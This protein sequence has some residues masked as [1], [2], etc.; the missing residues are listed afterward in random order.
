[1]AMWGWPSRSTLRT[2]F[3][4]LAI[5]LIVCP[6]ADGQQNKKRAKRRRRRAKGKDVYWYVWLYAKIMG[7]VLA[8]PVLLARVA[9]WRRRRTTRTPGPRFRSACPGGEGGGGVLGPATAPL[10]DQRGGTGGR[11]GAGRSRGGARQ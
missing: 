6:G 4:L 1:M 2:L 8:M 10:G 7:G 9:V 3:V 11:A 5:F